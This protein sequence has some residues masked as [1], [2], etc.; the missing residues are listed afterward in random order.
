MM[1]SSMIMTFNAVISTASVTD[2]ADD[3]SPTY[4][5]LSKMS[6]RQTEWM[7]RNAFLR[8][9]DLFFVRLFWRNLLHFTSRPPPR[10]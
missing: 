10:G 3:S 7:M 6:P 2:E 9:G 4:P 1:T 5:L 8:R